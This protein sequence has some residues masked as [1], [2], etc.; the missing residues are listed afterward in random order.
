MAEQMA[1]E[2]MDIEQERI[3]LKAAWV[4]GLGML[5]IGDKVRI[6][7]TAKCVGVAFEKDPKTGEGIR[8]HIIAAEEITA[9]EVVTDD[10]IAGLGN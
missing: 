9:T 2:G 7:G 6:E 8:I 3:K 1:F 5:H 10:T 4:A